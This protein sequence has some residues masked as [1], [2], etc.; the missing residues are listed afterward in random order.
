MEIPICE[1]TGFVISMLDLRCIAV[2][3]EISTVFVISVLYLRC[4]VVVHGDAQM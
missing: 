4:N 1:V 3:P 2:V